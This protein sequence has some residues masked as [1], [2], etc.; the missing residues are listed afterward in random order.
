MQISAEERRRIR[1]ERS[2]RWQLEHPERAREIQRQWRERHIDEANEKNRRWRRENPDKA[3]KATRRWRDKNRVR[4]RTAE[5]ERYRL[6]FTERRRIANERRELKKRRLV[7]ML[8]GKC[9]DCGQV[10]HLAAF[11]FDHVNGKKTKTV[12]IMLSTYSWEKIF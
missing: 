12:S 8:G 9:V 1:I 10:P 5:R 11:E 3:Y 7:E 4:V 6:V 2:A